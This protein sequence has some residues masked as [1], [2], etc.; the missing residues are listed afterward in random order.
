MAEAITLSIA[1]RIATVTLNRPEAM[2]TLDQAGANRWLE[3][4]TEVTGSEQVSAVLLRAEGRAFCAGGDLGA[5]ADLGYDGAALTTL[6]DTIHEGMRVFRD[7]SVPIVAAVQGAVAGGGLGLML[8]ADLIV[9]SDR[10][11]F[12]SRYANV[13]LT[14]DCGTSTFLTESIGVRRTLAFTLS[15]LGLDAATALDWGLITEIAAPEAVEARAREIAAGWA[16]GPAH[17]YGQARRLV[18]AAPTRSFTENL[19]DEARTIGAAIE[20]DDAR[21]RIAAFLGRA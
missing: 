18:R 12:F 20:T 19:A 7:G 15:D 9:A 6:A 4:A 17:A 3:V 21:A 16:S 11:K 8:A 10:A 13:G 5:M 2:N 1:D 14:P